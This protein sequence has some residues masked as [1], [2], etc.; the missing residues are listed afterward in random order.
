MNRKATPFPNDSTNKKG[1]KKP[2]KTL[3]TTL[4]GCLIGKHLNVEIKNGCKINGILD[5]V[6]GLMNLTIGHTTTTFPPHLKLGTK[7]AELMF[8]QGM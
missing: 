5:E 4:V 2:K 6:D 1:A 8:I 7:H 3:S